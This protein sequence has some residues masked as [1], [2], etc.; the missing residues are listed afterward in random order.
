MRPFR[1]LA[2]LVAVVPVAVGCSTVH[3][4]AYS[5]SDAPASLT[6]A[7]K[8]GL[9]VSVDAVLD[10]K[11][12]KKYFGT[13]TTSKGIVPVFVRVENISRTGSVLV[14]KEQFKVLVNASDLEGLKKSVEHSSTT[15]QVIGGAG[16]LLLASPLIVVGSIMIS[17]ADEV[18][19]NFAEKELRNQSLTRGRGVEGFFYCK[20][21]R[22][23]PIRR[24]LVSIP[25]RDLQTDQ[26]IQCDFII[27]NENIP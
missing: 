18:R 1:S 24:V 17:S 4:K 7:E 19:Q 6:T 23:E 27:K 26:K 12:T 13:D 9:R 14:E 8:D 2:I 3:P 15:G 20:Y 5:S 25:F 11:R 21:D 10:A 16:A 22:K